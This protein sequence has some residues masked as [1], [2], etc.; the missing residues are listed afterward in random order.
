MRALFD[1]VAI[2]LKTVRMLMGSRQDVPRH[3]TGTC[4]CSTGSVGLGP[5]GVFESMIHASSISALLK[6][7]TKSHTLWSH[8]PRQ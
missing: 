5:T 6:K 1:R 3:A 7:S 4:P 2:S 8:K